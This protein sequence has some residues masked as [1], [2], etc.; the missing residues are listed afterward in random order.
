M[1]INKNISNI[2]VVDC[3][4]AAVNAVPTNGAEQGVAIK[5]A[6]NPLK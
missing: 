4:N 5:V 3:V 2:I 1:P 6:K